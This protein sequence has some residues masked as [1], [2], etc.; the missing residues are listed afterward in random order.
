MKK[1][2]KPLKRGLFLLAACVV[3]VTLANPIYIKGKQSDE[4]DYFGQSIAL[5]D[6]LLFVGAPKDDTDYA[7]PT[8]P[9]NDSNSSGIVYLYRKD[10]NGDWYVSG[11]LIGDDTD[12]YDNFGTAMA[13]DGQRLVVSA[14]YANS[15]GAVYVFGENAS[16]EWV[17]QAKLTPDIQ[18]SDDNFGISVAL[19]GDTMVVGASGEDS[20]DATDPEDGSVTASGAAYIFEFDGSSWQQ[21]AYLKSD[22]IQA[23]ARFGEVVAISGTR[24]WVGAPETDNGSDT[25]VGRVIEFRKTGSNWG[26]HAGYW[27]EGSDDKY[28]KALASN[29]AFVA[30]GAQYADMPLANAGK[31]Y[32]VDIADDNWA[33]PTVITAATPAYNMGFG[34][35]LAF[36]NHH[37]VVGAFSEDGSGNNI[38]PPDDGTKISNSGA[39]FVFERQAGSWQQIHRLKASNTETSDWFGFAVA[40]RDD[41][42]LVNARYE[43]SR[44]TGLDGDMTDNSADRS[45]AAYLFKLPITRFGVGGTI[46]GLDAG[47]TVTLS[48]HGSEIGAFANGD[49]SFPVGL[50][51]GS[52]YDVTFAP[53]DEKTC[54]ID[55]A[56]G[57]ITGSDITNIN[58]DCVTVT[59]PLVGAFAA[60]DLPLSGELRIINHSNGETL[61]IGT[62]YAF[63]F[64]TKLAA[65]EAYDVR[66]HS[67]PTGYACEV[68]NPRGTMPAGG[69][70]SH[71]A[72]SCQ[73]VYTLGGQVNHL[74]GTVVLENNTGE[75]LTLTNSNPAEAT[76]FT[77]AD[78]YVNGD[79]YTLRVVSQPDNQD[80][81]V[82]QAPITGTFGT[83]NVTDVSLSCMDLVTLHTAVIGNGSLSPTA[84]TAVP[85]G[86]TH[87]FTITPD[88]GWQLHSVNGCGGSLS[89]NTYTATNVTADC[90]VTVTL[91]AILTYTISTQLTGQGSITPA[92]ATGL[93][94]GD[95]QTFT[96]T[97]ADGWQLHSVS[98]CDGSLSGAIY[99]VPNVTADCTVYANFQAVS[100]A[101]KIFSDSFEAVTP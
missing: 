2:L 57:T 101:G 58:I 56:S 50:L 45:G 27:G 32:L 52:T 76:L 35:S 15:R 80:C 31:V 73:A 82:G 91:Q 72:V 54:T 1:R 43:D 53:P 11:T 14:D 48:N 86:G 59:Y 63:V 41:E 46:T 90:T 24:V 70:V 36:S 65:G 8:I 61:A 68:S 92:E 95:N 25:N 62:N 20:G 96:L 21:T 83:A 78:D 16:G 19:D 98:G 49:Y 6:G 44:T 60:P 30:V 28:G 88:D 94:A 84:I 17:Q 67:E 55:N 4:H 75:R 12:I 34:S 71:L 47:Q 100:V 10:Y 99:T 26:L 40:M 89:G 77:F 22:E 97:P 37:L 3:S 85:S 13:L 69:D 9:N 93:H 51:M 81:G 18:S 38:D 74:N 33:S 29:S 5:G 87:T 42:V 7:S 23:S 64:A 39:A 66:I 79:A